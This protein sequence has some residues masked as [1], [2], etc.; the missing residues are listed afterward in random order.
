MVILKKA[1]VGYNNI[2]KT[3]TEDM[4][5]GTNTKVNYVGVKKK[6]PP[7]KQHQPDTPINHLDTL[8]GKTESEDMND[9][10]LNTLHE[11]QQK[12]LVKTP[13][14][15]MIHTPKHTTYGVTTN[16]SDV[17]SKTGIYLAASSLVTFLDF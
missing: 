12:T 2:L 11:N 15:C 7:K 14:K 13:E 10:N 17:G 3:A 16:S 9:S 4:K 5:F 8:D 6:D 1:V